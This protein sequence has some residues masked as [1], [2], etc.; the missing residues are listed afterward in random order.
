MYWKPSKALLKYMF[1]SRCFWFVVQNYLECLVCCCPFD[2][3][4]CW[5][6]ITHTGKFCLKVLITE[7]RITVL[8]LPNMFANHNIFLQVATHPNFSINTCRHIL[9]IQ[10]QYYS[11]GL[12][13]INFKTNYPAWFTL[14][15]SC[16]GLWIYWP[17]P[18][19]YRM[20]LTSSI[21]VYFYIE[22]I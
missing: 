11:M 6:W 18:L 5:G 2:A 20:I 21:K 9:V 12:N 17:T 13:P 19:S 16:F 14:F 1:S 7:C 10:H 4:Y 8:W 3:S 22:G 15:H